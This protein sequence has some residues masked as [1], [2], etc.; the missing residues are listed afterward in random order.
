MKTSGNATPSSDEIMQE[1]GWRGNAESPDRWRKFNDNSIR[2]R[3]KD[4]DH[5]VGGERSD[6]E[7]ERYGRG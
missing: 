6:G 5:G 2:W 3:G 4:K 7:R 1:R